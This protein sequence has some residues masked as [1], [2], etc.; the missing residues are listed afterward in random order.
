MLLR[1]VLLTLACNLLD[2]LPSSHHS[3]RHLFR[4]IWMTRIYP[5]TT[6]CWV[7]HTF[8]MYVGV[9]CRLT[10]S[11][12]PN[13]Y[14]LLYMSLGS[15]WISVNSRIHKYD[16]ILWMY[17]SLVIESPKVSINKMACH[18]R[19]LS[20][21]VVIISSIPNCHHIIPVHIRLYH[22]SSFLAQ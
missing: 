1:C 9:I 4:F 3:A 15:I 12:D 2:C 11:I 21:L 19:S 13:A 16:I 20:V 22:H 8:M 10:Y 6:F 18:K 5:S 7:Y 17:K 14:E